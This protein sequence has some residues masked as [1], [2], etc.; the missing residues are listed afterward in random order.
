MWWLLYLACFIAVVK[1]YKWWSIRPRKTFKDKIVL[2][3]G[4]GSGLGRLQAQEFAKDGAKV[5]LWDLRDDLMQETKKIIM[6]VNKD[7]VVHTYVVDLSDKDLIEKQAEVLK[8]E[9]GEVDVL[10][11]NAGIVSGKTFLECPDK[12]MILTMQVNAIA[13][14]WTVKAFLPNMIKNNSGHIITLASAA[15][16]CG[17]AGLADYCASKHA[18]VGFD[19]S[20]RQELRKTG[21]TGVKT[22][23]VCPY[24]INTGMFKGVKTRIPAI[25]PILEPEYV[26]QRIMSAARANHAILCLPEVVRYTPVFRALMPTELFDFFSSVLGISSSMDD[27]KGRGEEW[28]GKQLKKED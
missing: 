3:T 23:V 24:Y 16:T 26:V 28:A 14:F 20:I 17:V 21:K 4:G 12:L 18:A 5:V 8:A 6:D 7:A 11:N 2:V 19:E 25:L 1:A 22:T 10:V 9:V 13:H 15:G 27:F